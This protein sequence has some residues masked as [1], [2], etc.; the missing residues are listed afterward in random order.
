MNCNYFSFFFLYNMDFYFFTKVFSVAKMENSEDRLH[1]VSKDK[2]GFCK[3]PVVVNKGK[4][5]IQ[6]QIQGKEF[7]PI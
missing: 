5:T 7:Q 3:D 1:H 6:E 2:D 4:E